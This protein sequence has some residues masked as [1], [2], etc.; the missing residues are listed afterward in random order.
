MVSNKYIGLVCM[1]IVMC[2]LA[3]FFSYARAQHMHL[4]ANISSA[5]VIT[6][7][8]SAAVT[9]GAEN[10][11]QIGAL[12][13]PATVYYLPDTAFGPVPVLISVIDD[14]TLVATITVDGC[15]MGWKWE[16]SDAGEDEVVR[17]FYFSTHENAT[18]EIQPYVC[19]PTSSEK[20]EIACDSLYWNG[21]WR[22]ASG[23]YAYTTTNA[24][25]CDSIVTLHLTINHSTTSKETLTEC[26][27]LFWNDQWYKESGNYTFKTTNAAGC[28]SIA[29]LHLTINQSY[30]VALPDTIIC[31]DSFW[32]GYWLVDTL[33]MTDGNYT[34]KTKTVGG[35]D[36]II[37]QTVKIR[38]VTYG[39]TTVTAYDSYTTNRKETYTKSFENGGPI[40]DYTNAAGC[41]SI[42][43]VRLYIR[44]LQVNDTIVRS[45]CDSELP[46]KW[47]DKTYMEGGL[48]TT[49]TIQGIKVNGVYM[50]T[51][52]TMNLTVLPS[53]KSEETHSTES[54]YTWHDITYEKSGDYTYTT[55]NAVGCDSVV[56]LHLTINHPV[57]TVSAYFCP[58]SGIVEHVDMTSNPRIHYIPYEYEKP[59]KEWYM[60]G[61]VTGEK[62]DGAY[63]N[64]LKPVQNLHEHYEGEEQL[65]PVTTIYWRYRERGASSQTE[66]VINRTQ[67]QWVERG[68]ISIEVQFQCGQRFYDSFTVGDMTEDME[69]VSGEEQAIKRME[70]GQV[71]IIRNGA[72]YT[73]LGTKIQ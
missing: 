30:H 60:E 69:Q 12:N 62:N 11:F 70:N 4:G 37:T 45:I 24:A 19:N 56:T 14:D 29:T 22:Y 2:L 53:S 36:S 28:D 71:V 55:T 42:V 17:Y 58:K 66:V 31:T 33:I 27:S 40:D 49:D 21:E 59:S 8:V 35:C 32:D 63:V 51:V 44:H 3:P 38:Y 47:Y 9:D 16:L 26:D 43:T 39:T 68:T 41:D 52:H 67:P 54:S 48:F 20:T 73:I 25:G 7:T 15:R 18:A 34:R 64:F 72:K 46:F 61:V 13:L 10:Y 5:P 57:D 65:T 6:D 1:T 23:D 50:D